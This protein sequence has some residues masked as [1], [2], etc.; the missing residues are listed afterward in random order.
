MK[1][2]NPIT[3]KDPL[4]GDG[5]LVIPRYAD[6]KYEDIILHNKNCLIKEGY[7]LKFRPL[8]KKTF[9]SKINKDGWYDDSK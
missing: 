2:I 8:I 1:L 5:S 4:N 3:I 6:E 7:V 9:A